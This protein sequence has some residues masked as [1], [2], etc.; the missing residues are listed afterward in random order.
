MVDKFLL[1]F[2]SALFLAVIAIGYGP[3]ILAGQHD[4]LFAR[5]SQILKEFRTA[6]DD[7]EKLD[8]QRQNQSAVAFLPWLVDMEEDIDSNTVKLLGIE[9]ALNIT[10]PADVNEHTIS[11]NGTH[12]IVNNNTALKLP[13]GVKQLFDSGLTNETR[14]A[15]EEPSGIG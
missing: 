5:V 15:I 10:S 2:I 12:V 4:E 11:V 6:D 7:R 1:I 14:A 9:K 8:I 3:V 13:F